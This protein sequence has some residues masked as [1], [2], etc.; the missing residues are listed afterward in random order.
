MIKITKCFTCFLSSSPL[1]YCINLIDEI[2]KETKAHRDFSKG[3][4]AIKNG[5]DGLDF[6]YWDSSKGIIAKV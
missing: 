3:I 5:L 1:N 6:R 2:V 4:A